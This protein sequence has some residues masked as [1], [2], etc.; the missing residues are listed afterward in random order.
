MTFDHLSP[1]ELDEH[2]M[3]RSQLRSQS[4]GTCW[5]SDAAL[6]CWDVRLTNAD[7]FEETM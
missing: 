2:A 5:H 7:N 6:S 1:L 4:Q 3:G